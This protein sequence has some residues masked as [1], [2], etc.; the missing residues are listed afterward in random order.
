MTEASFEALSVHRA[1]DLIPIRSVVRVVVTCLRCH[2]TVHPREGLLVTSECSTCP[3][4]SDVTYTWKLLVNKN[5][6]KRQCPKVT[7]ETVT[8]PN[9]SSTTKTPKTNPCEQ[10][11]AARPTGSPSRANQGGK[12]GRGAMCL[13][14]REF[15]AVNESVCKPNFGGGHGSSWTTAAPPFEVT[16][17]SGSTSNGGLKDGATTAPP[18]RAEEWKRIGKS[19][20]K[21]IAGPKDWT[22]LIPGSWDWE[23]RENKVTVDVKCGGVKCG[24]ASLRFKA[25]YEGCCVGAYLW[26]PA[27]GT[28]LATEFKLF[29]LGRQPAVSPHVQQ[30]RAHTQKTRTHIQQTRAHI[31]QRRARTQKTR[32]H[33]QKTRAHIQQTR[34]HSAGTRAHSENTRA[35][36]A[37]TRTHSEN[38]RAHSADART[39]S[40]H[41]R[42]FSK[43]ARTFSKRAQIQQTLA[44]TSP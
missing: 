36:S 25:Q 7:N 22:V 11:A 8:T 37:D 31:Q 28:E 2:G 29:S 13:S 18:T 34:V 3:N 9:T 42:T 1:V 10:V 5:A 20:L 27:N 16:A 15:P 40:R 35:H 38:T 44:T 33:T 32:A 39:F 41:A 26:A 19:P 24:S 43:H 30:T 23:Y 12:V 21:G 4:K 14:D 17:G 6:G